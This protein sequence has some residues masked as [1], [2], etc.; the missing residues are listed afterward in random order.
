M[1]Y[2]AA[3]QH[4]STSTSLALALAT[5]KLK[6]IAAMHPGIWE[7]TVLAKFILTAGQFTKGRAAVN[8][9]SG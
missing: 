2:G 3:Q 1:V 4:E 8:V 5:E 6:V 7:P 9:V